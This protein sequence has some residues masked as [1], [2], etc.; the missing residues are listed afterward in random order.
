MTLG[1]LDKVGSADFN[2]KKYLFRRFSKFY[3]LHWVCLAA[4]IL[5]AMMS[6]M[7]IGDVKTFLAN[8]LLI[9][10]WIPDS[11]FYF[12]FNGISWYLS[13]TIF[14]AAVFPFIIKLIINRSGKVNIIFCCIWASLY[15]A[16]C[17]IVPEHLRHAILY[18]NPLVRLADFI[19]GIYT[20]KLFLLIKQLIKL[21]FHQAPPQQ[22]F[23]SLLLLLLFQYHLY[24]CFELKQS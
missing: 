4:W 22:T 18:I 10:S 17:L 12:S 15:A 13:N 19:V 11:K 9:Q 14:F 3:P 8:V 2:Y 21:I 7:Q 20:A 24:P 23:L 1:Y 16:V 5:L 6:S